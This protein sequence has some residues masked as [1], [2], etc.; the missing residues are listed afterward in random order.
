MISSRPGWIAQ[1]RRQL[2]VPKKIA[3][4]YLHGLTGLIANVIKQLLKLKLP[5]T[6]RFANLITLSVFVNRA[7]VVVITG[8]HQPVQLVDRNKHLL[9]HILSLVKDQTVQVV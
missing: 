2:F 1:L 5:S 3:V 4:K 6:E 9:F 7:S 8:Q